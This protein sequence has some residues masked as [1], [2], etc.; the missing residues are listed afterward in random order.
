MKLFYA[1]G[2]CSLASHITLEELGLPYEAVRLNLM[3]GEQRKP[4]Y[5]ALNPKG[6]VPAL[7]T[8]QGVLTESPAIL[9]YLAGLKPDAD[10]LPAD[11]WA[12]GQ[13][14]S[15]L[16][17]CSGTVHGIGFAGLFRAARFASSEAGQADV[18]ATA[19]E[20]VLA[21]MTDIEA[22]YQGKDWLF[23]AFG[24]ADLYPVIF[25]RWAARVGLDI[26]AYPNLAGL[27]ARLAARP[28]AARVIAREGIELD[29]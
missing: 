29:R 1:P 11:P 9:V 4:E 8:E 22:R 2:A 12:R 24:V 28:A 16:V 5:L 13:A 25:R 6:R 15:F 7:A 10:L 26:A 18:K 20:T 19:R 14:V 17:W 27:A 3:E 21:G 23:G